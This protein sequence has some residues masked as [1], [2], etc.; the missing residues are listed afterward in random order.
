MQPP[1][2]T[3]ELLAA[4][5]KLTTD[6]VKGL[7][8]GNDGGIGV[9]GGPMLW[10]AGLDYL[11]QDQTAFGFDGRRGGAGLPAHAVHE[12]VAPARAPRPTGPTPRPSPRASARC[13]GPAC[14]P[15]PSIE[16][17]FPG[18]YG[19]MA[20][21]KSA[22]TGAPSVPV[23]AYGSCVSAKS[24]NPDAAK[25]FAKWLWVDQTDKQLDF[26]QSYGF[27]IPARKSVAA[28]AEQAEVRA[29]RRRRQVRQRER[30]RAVAAALDAE[31]R[32][33]L[34]RRPD[35]HRQGRRRPGGR[36]RDDEDDR[37]G[38]AQAR[39]RVSTPAP[40]GA[41]AAAAAA[42]QPGP[43]PVVLGLRRAVRRSGW[44][45]SSTSPSSGASGSASTTRATRSRPTTFV[46]FGN[47]AD[48]LADPAFRSSM[49]TFLVFAAFIVP[50]TFALSLGL[51][52]LVNRA[53][54]SSRSSARSSSCRPPAPTSWPR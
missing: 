5:K 14:G 34:L 47:Y 37:R 21:P 51:A 2:T 30:P 31:V 18:D 41:P 15:C 28:K 33:G 17:A 32:D 29:G 19:V 10:S 24:R 6:K 53:R 26:A 23:G 20:W 25:A 42:R 38:R 22:A 54:G 49:L 13:S 50:T 3:D 39:Q 48:M 40:A 46:G 12:R 7:F 27:H 52:L 36:D 11:N 9:L 35:P 43:Q 44:S 16:K 1:T 8:V 4:A 45:S